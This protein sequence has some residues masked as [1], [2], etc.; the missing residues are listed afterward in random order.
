MRSETLALYCLAFWACQGDNLILGDGRAADSG[1]DSAAPQRDFQPP[2]VIAELESEDVSD[3][4]P[5]LTADLLDLCFNSK[6]DGG[7]GAEDIWCSRRM[8]SD[9]TW[10]APVAQI[11]LNT[12]RRETGIAL[13]L[14]GLSLWFSSDREG[15]SGLDVYTASR[16]TRDAAWSEVARVA[17]LST[18]DDDLVSSVDETGL[19]LMMARRTRSDDDDDDAGDY[20]ILLSERTTLSDPWQAPSAVS[21]LNSD[22][23]ESD[24]YLIGKGLDVVFSRKDDLLW[25]QRSQTNAPFDHITALNVLNSEKRERDAW[26]N[27][28]FTYIV[29]SSDRAG[30]F[31]LYEAE[32]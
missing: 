1:V 32:R 28:A 6:R 30:S 29:F 25:A 14:D 31:R 20:D 2:R 17:E 23:S 9:E 19:R 15:A 24:A 27:S 7:M 22:E 21:E 18:A 11:A 3:D 4:D 26:S 8:H 10:S 5:S 16:P 13:A 12:E